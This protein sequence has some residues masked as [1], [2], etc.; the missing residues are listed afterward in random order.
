MRGARS[1]NSDLARLLRSMAERHAGE[2]DVSTTSQM[3]AGRCDVLDGSIRPILERRGWTAGVDAA[4][5]PHVG[6]SPSGGAGRSERSGAA[7]LLDL[8]D[9]SVA[10]HAAELDWTVVRQA[11]L[12]T[13]DE[14][15]LRLATLGTDEARRV[16]RWAKTRIKETVPQSLASAE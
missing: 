6:S 15:L 11:A 2:P 3:L 7:L 4:T 5:P 9:L 12:A 10:A 8:R 1:S 16:G 14:E 13:R